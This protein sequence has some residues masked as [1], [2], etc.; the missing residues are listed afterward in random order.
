MRE[1][2]QFGK[3]EGLHQLTEPRLAAD[4]Y[5]GWAMTAI[6]TRI[7]GGKGAY[8]CPDENG[9][10]YVVY[11][12]IKAADSQVVAVSPPPPPSDSTVDCEVHGVG[13][14]AFACEHLVLNPK[15]KWHSD[16][17]TIANPW[18][19]AWCAKC[20]ELFQ[21]RGKWDEQ[22]S[23]RLEIKLLCHRCYESFRKHEQPN[24][25]DRVINSR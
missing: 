3:A 15:Q 21:E 5:L 10:M 23:E 7:I 19:D 18:P 9:F 2:Q 4:E 22:N 6:M 12:D 8:R 20:D 14:S 16:D 17:P 11:T 25:P 1:V 24:L 13:Q